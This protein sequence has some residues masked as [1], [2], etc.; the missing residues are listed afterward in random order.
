MRP[1]SR[2]FADP[3]LGTR[4]A[5]PIEGPDLSSPTQEAAQPMQMEHAGDAAKRKRGG[6]KDK[7]SKEKHPISG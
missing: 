2:N 6:H 4:R 3:R 7:S 5:E 1:L